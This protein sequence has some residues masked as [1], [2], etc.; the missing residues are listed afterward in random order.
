M[1]LA[2]ADSAIMICGQCL[3]R[4][5]HFHACVAPFRY[6]YPLDRLIQGLKYRGQMAYGRVLG[7]LLANH[8][9]ARPRSDLPQLLIPTPL[10]P[11]RYRA[12]G[13]NQSHEIAL[14]LARALQIDL[15]GDLLIRQRETG[16][17]AGLKQ[18]ERRRNVRHAFAL[19]KPLSADQVAILDDVITTGSTANEMAKVLR[20]AGA[21]RVEAW[22]LARS[23]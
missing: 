7:R 19:V 21:K 16:E 11:R 2:S 10:A 9:L 6:D 3:R 20:R 15:R 12:R 14:P 18:A 5:P 8:L 1:P 17:Q 22:A 23:V 13:F 4:A